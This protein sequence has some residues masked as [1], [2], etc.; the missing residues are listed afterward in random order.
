MGS[1]SSRHTYE[2]RSFEVTQPYPGTDEVSR[3]AYLA[4][5]L[6][7]HP[8]CCGPGLDLSDLRT[9]SQWGSLEPFSQS[10]H[11]FRRKSSQ[12]EGEVPPPNTFLHPT[13]HQILPGSDT[14]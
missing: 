5:L 6:Q 4:L 10:Q 1:I 8:Y 3:A 2:G 14:V 9:E 7:A 12:H 11:F 13:L